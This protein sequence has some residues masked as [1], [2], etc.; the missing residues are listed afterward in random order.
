MII[1]YNDSEFTEAVI[2]LQ[3]KQSKNKN[4]KEE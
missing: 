1:L 2:F 3:M 4:A